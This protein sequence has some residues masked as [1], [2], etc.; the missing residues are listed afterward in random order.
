MG[1][2]NGKIQAYGRTVREERDT[3]IKKWAQLLE[4]KK[5]DLNI[6]VDKEK[7]IVMKYAHEL[8]G[9]L[10]EGKVTSQ[11]IFI[12]LAHRCTTVGFYFNHI[13]EVDF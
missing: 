5:R 13:T 10:N 9:L 8:A 4:Q 11:E 3:E 12:V 2:K 6:S 1:G 7:E